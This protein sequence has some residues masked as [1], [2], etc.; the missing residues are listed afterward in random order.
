MP[1]TTHRTLAWYKLHFLHVRK[2]V[3]LTQR[4]LTVSK[5]HEV[6]M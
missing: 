3:N 5:A 6:R 4:P 1:A 2:Y